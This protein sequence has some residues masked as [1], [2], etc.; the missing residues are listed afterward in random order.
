MGNNAGEF[1]K[2][3]NYDLQILTQIRSYL[4]D[5]IAGFLYEHHDSDDSSLDLP[6]LEQDRSNTEVHGVLEQHQVDG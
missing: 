1:G 2:Y 3:G 5:K 6:P 4:P